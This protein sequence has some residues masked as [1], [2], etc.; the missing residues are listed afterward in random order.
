MRQ[1]TIVHH[2]II[3]Y[4]E[5]AHLDFSAT[6]RYIQQYC[7]IISLSYLFFF[8]SLQLLSKTKQ[9]KTTTK[10]NSKKQ[11]QKSEATYEYTGMRLVVVGR[12]HTA[13]PLLAG[14]V[15]EI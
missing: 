11:Q 2:H 10:N 12:M 13:E 5:I 1:W 14:R 3:K 6:L 4:S 9:K 15:P 8:F 7:V